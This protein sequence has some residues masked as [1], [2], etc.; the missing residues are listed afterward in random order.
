MAWPKGGTRKITV[1]GQE[2]LWH[3]DA[4]CVFCSD[5][6][7][8][9]GKEGTPYVLFI[10]PFPV[11]MDM[12]PRGVASAIRWARQQGWTPDRGP[13]RAMTLDDDTQAFRWLGD[14]QRHAVCKSKRVV[15]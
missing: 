1:D 11:S 14:G 4:C 10:D 8:T 3:Y 7:L 5:D 2:F 13:T 12:G 6:V 15:E 9:A